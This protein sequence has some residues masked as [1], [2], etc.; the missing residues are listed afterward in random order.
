VSPIRFNPF[1]VQRGVHLS[2]HIDYLKAIFN[3]SFS[4][5]GPMP[6]IVEK[7]IHNIY[8]KKGWS[9]TKGFHP[10]FTD[11]QG[12]YDDSGYDTPQHLYFFPTRSDLKNEGGNA[13]RYIDMIN[14]AIIAT[15]I[16]PYDPAKSAAITINS[17]ESNIPSSTLPFLNL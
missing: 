3:A 17:A 10:N 9:I 11:A 7:C 2:E 13:S 1:Y 15:T 16:P 4:L 8:A 5:Y 12:Q 6:A 14:D